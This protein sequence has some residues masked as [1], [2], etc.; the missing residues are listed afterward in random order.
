MRNRRC[1][2]GYLPA[3]LPGEYAALGKLAERAGF[4]FE[5]R[6]RGIP[7]AKF[8]ISSNSKQ[9]NRVVGLRPAPCSADQ[10]QS[11]ALVSRKREYSRYRSET[12]GELGSY[13]SELGARRPASNSRK[14]A[15]GGTFRLKGQP[16]LWHPHCLAGDAV[17]IAPVSRPI[18]C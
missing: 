16:L 17:L 2:W 12:F 9:R 10:T 8:Q 14:P 4:E 5:V 11:P 18:P 15:I 1:C 13:D 6:S 7:T 3:I